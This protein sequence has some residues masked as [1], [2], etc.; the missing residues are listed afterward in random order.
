MKIL[1]VNYEHPPVGGGGGR[2]AAEV[3]RQLCG[4]GHEIRVLTSLAPGLPRREHAGA[5]SLHRVWCARRKP[6]TCSVP[7]MA[8]WVAAG[9]LPAAAT[10]LAWKPE[11]IHVH[12]AVPSGPVAW[13][14]SR[15][16]GVPYVL[17]A[18]LGDVPG[19]AP[20]QT[21][22]LFRWLKP[23]T[24][25]VWRGA[26]RVTVVSSFVARLAR[27]AYGVE[28]RVILNGT[29]RRAPTPPP[30]PADGVPR[31]LY[32]GRMSVQKNTPF[33]GEVLGKLRDV[34]W[35]AVF[36]GEGPLRGDL[37]KSLRAGGVMDRCAFRGWAGPEEVWQAMRGADLLLMPSLS[38]GL[39]MTA[40]E[41]SAAGVA[42]AGSDIPGLDDVLA[43]GGNGLRL[44][45]EAEAWVRALRPLLA[46]APRLAAMKEAALALAERFDLERT[47]DAYEEELTGAARKG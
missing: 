36:L 39:P 6:D 24:V 31:L 26:R 18:H 33:L 7:E 12:F 28:P 40:I 3:A 9:A 29:S 34:P 25:P 44:P 16:S 38:E 11:V 42:L 2:L 10:A 43:G 46:D 21:D 5:L 32:V 41:A 14:A 45:L 20:E 22:R 27:E 4:R 37:E 8:A 47:V 17:T 1:L 23:F 15:L 30:P 13:L 35:R 19:G